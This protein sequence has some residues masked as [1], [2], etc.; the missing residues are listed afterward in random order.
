[1]TNTGIVCLL[2]SG[3][4]T[5]ANASSINDGASA[6]VV[7]TAGAASR[8]G[9]KSLARIVSKYSASEHINQGGT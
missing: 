4:I 7:M 1:M 6:V 9:L 3:T 2:L 8:L 5:A